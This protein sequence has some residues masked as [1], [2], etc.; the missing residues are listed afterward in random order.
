MAEEIILS[1]A[2]S[3]DLLPRGSKNQKL[4]VRLKMF[5]HDA[6][7]RQHPQTACD[8]VLA[9]DTSQSMDEPFKAGSHLTKREGVVKAATAMVSSLNPDDTLGLICYDSAGY[10]EL[11]RVPGRD[12]Q[13]IQQAI[14]TKISQHSGGTNF[15][16]AFERAKS[17]FTRHGHASR[18]LCFLTDGNQTEGSPQRAADLNGEIAALGVV[19]DCLGVGGDFNFTEMQK[20]T[21]VSNGR[22]E[23]LDTPEQAQRTFRELLRNAQQSLISQ[24]VLRITLDSHLRDVEFYQLT[25]E[26]RV[27]TPQLQ[28]ARD[29]T[30][31][32]RINLQS[33]A[34]TFNYTY[35]LR[36]NLDVAAGAKAANIALGRVRLDYDVPVSKLTGQVIENTI[37]LNVADQSGQ[38]IHDHTVE[39][40]ALE[41]SL[42]LLNQR[43]Q[44]AAAGDDWKQVATVLKQMID[45]ANTLGDSDKRKHYQQRLDDLVKKGRL[46][47]EELNTIG[48]AS[49]KSTRL[50]GGERET[51]NPDL[52]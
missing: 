14:A 16:A 23:L 30:R 2:L 52:Y 41:A 43:A 46:S 8:V 34:Q 32:G 37:V 39:Q 24:A 7:V 29:G 47:R 45:H 4:D 35:V 49:T 19:V 42:E 38:E 6:F 3:R 44:T 25:P 21:A 15:E 13:A 11:N 36:C 9:I 33:M 31:S 20:Y 18:R 51:R 22:T 40:D 5:T 48:S 26:I 50:R 28:A 17:L 27:L 10:I 1:T 12:K